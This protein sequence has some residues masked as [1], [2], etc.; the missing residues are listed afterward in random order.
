LSLDEFRPLLPLVASP[1]LDSL[2][3]STPIPE[4]QS[5]VDFLLAR[6]ILAESANNRLSAQLYYA[7]AALHSRSQIDLDSLAV[8]PHADL[9][10]A[11]VGLGEIREAT[12][13]ANQA[14]A[15]LERGGHVSGS[16]T[17]GTE[18]TH[19]SVAEV[20]LRSRNWNQAEIAVR[21]LLESPGYLSPDWIKVDPRFTQT[22]T[23]PSYRGAKQAFYHR[24]VAPLLYRDTTPVCPPS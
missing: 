6:A 15:L 12:R 1:H 4:S 21:R 11:L 24:L 18:A 3:E 2:M 10:L 20:Y 22:I 19:W 9:A 17:V 13:K 5:L 8:E 23:E 7:S 14:L 16:V